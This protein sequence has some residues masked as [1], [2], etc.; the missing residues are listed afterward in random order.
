MTKRVQLEKHEDIT[1]A[2][3][4]SQN[5]GTPPASQTPADQGEWDWD[6]LSLSQDFSTG[7][8]AVRPLPIA[9]DK[10]KRHEFFRIHPSWRQQTAVLKIQDDQ[11]TEC[12]LVGRQVREAFLSDVQVVELVV[13]ITR[14][15]V[16]GVW[17]LKCLPTDRRPSSWQSTAWEAVTLAQKSWV[18][19][20]P[21]LSL[22]CYEI[23]E[24]LG[25]V[26]EPVWPEG[27][28]FEDVVRRAF[29]DGFSGTPDHPVLRRLRG[30][31]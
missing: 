26:P 25:N 5:D 23:Y 6:E 4:P 21:N 2:L 10:P 20:V 28:T 1:A 29:K 30:E 8:V 15:G 9:A 3:A 18:R 12:Y 31:I 14:S 17:P 11:A 24:A 13:W 16:L 22:G 7:A 27:L 19:L